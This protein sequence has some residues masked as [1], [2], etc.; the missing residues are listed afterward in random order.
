M[1]EI[2]RVF[3]HTWKS[4]KQFLGDSKKIREMMDDF[5]ACIFASLFLE[6][7]NFTML[8][9]IMCKQSFLARKKDV[10]FLC[11]RKKVI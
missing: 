1:I 8:G 2:A 3:H 9:Y 7:K 10:Y 4:Q 11:V 6:A 5:G